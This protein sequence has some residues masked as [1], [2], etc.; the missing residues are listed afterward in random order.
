MFELCL[1]RKKTKCRVA[2]IR[3][4]RPH[5]SYNNYDIYINMNT[6]VLYDLHSRTSKRDSLHVA[7][8]I[9]HPPPRQHTTAVSASAT[10]RARLT[11]S[12]MDA[13]FSTGSFLFHKT[14]MFSFAS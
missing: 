12:N 8:L 13:S 1:P 3:F 5:H 10:E 4:V 11:P 9:P 7:H 14:I 6:S 2:T